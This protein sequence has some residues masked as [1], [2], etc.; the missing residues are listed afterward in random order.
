MTRICHKRNINN[1]PSIFF[2]K[3]FCG[4][5]RDEIILPTLLLSIYLYMKIEIVKS[6]QEMSSLQLKLKLCSLTYEMYKTKH[7]FSVEIGSDN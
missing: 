2:I 3:T 4:A 5:G 7:I 6:R 1:I